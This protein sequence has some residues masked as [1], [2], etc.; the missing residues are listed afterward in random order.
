MNARNCSGQQG[1]NPGRSENEL[2]LA[3]LLYP[4]LRAPKR[5][6]CLGN[7]TLLTTYLCSFYFLIARFTPSG[8]ASV[9]VGCL[10]SADDRVANVGGLAHGNS[11]ELEFSSFGLAY[12]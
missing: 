2:L 12:Q 11:A 7:F 8:E 1:L 4:Q 3:F 6:L 5:K 10:P 9:C